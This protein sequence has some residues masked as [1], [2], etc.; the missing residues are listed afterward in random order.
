MPKCPLNVWIM[1]DLKIIVNAMQV[2]KKIYQ[3][4]LFLYLGYEDQTFENPIYLNT[5]LKY[6][7]RL[8]KLR[9]ASTYEIWETHGFAPDTNYKH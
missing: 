7:T 3:F 9:Y 4:Q 2:L 8:S 6:A 5:R 1:R